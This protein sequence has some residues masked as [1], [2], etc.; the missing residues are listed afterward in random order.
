[1]THTLNGPSQVQA[2]KKSILITYLQCNKQNT[3]AKHTSKTSKSSLTFEEWR[4]LIHAFKIQS[5]H[6][7]CLQS[8]SHPNVGLIFCNEPEKM[9]RS[10]LKQAFLWRHKN[11]LLFLLPQQNLVITQPLGAPSRSAVF[12][13]PD[14]VT[15]SSHYDRR[16]TDSPDCFW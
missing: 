7:A 15:Q 14:C 13:F 6:Q 3:Q 4:A 1:M 12:Y 2:K 9:A 10:C 16:M 11:T 5:K 8:E